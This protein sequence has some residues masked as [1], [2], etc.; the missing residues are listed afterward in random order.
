VDRRF[1]DWRDVAEGLAAE[2]M[3]VRGELESLRQRDELAR[4]LEEA[5]RELDS[6]RAT[7]NRSW[8]LRLMNASPA[9]SHS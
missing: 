7:A 4:E 9:L 1:D 2:L 6:L 5:R 8:W 3:A